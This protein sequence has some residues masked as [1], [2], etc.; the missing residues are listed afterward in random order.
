MQNRILEAEISYLRK[1]NSELVEDGLLR[2]SEESPL[3]LGIGNE[4]KYSETK[5][6]ESLISQLELKTI[7][8]GFIVVSSI[9]LRSVSG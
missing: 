9:N 4:R 1:R 5:G 6:R 2:Y 7:E 8:V 3:R